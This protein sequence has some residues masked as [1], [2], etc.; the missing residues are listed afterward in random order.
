MA[1]PGKIALLLLVGLWV[2]GGQ[3]PPPPEKPA[4]VAPTIKLPLARL[5]PD[6]SI[7][8][9]G[10]RVLASGDAG[11]WVARR[12]AGTVSKIDGKTNKPGDPI[13]VGKEPCAG[14]VTGFGSLIVPLCGAPGVARVDLKT[15]E[16]KTVAASVGSG[17]MGP[18]TGVSSIWL[19]TDG[20]RRLVRLDPESNSL[21]ADM[22]LN[23]KALAMAFGQGALWI[24]TDNNELLKISPYTVVTNEIMKVGKSPI[25]IA[26]GEG[27]IWTLNAGDGSVSRVDPKTNKLA[28][29]ITLGVPISR[30]QIAAGEG[31]IWVSAVGA[32]LLRID[33]RT[34]HVVQQFTGEGGGAV[35]VAQGAIWV[36]ATPAAV[37]RLDPKLIDATR[38]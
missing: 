9:A 34:N 38:N 8:L 12:E 1:F 28:N 14:L 30:G 32:P 35:L 3:N 24:A 37:W 22:P 20:G 29:T 4:P 31:S 13:A 17:A 5:K 25:S 15:N 27:A 21:V 23:A 6:A 11:I 7:D 16:V 36:T 10:N 26:L 33:P 2:T 19:V 18:V